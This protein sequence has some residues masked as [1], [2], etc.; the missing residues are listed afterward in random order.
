MTNLRAY[1]HARADDAPQESEITNATVSPSDPGMIEWEGVVSQ[2]TPA[3]QFILFSAQF[4][5][6]EHSASASTTYSYVQDLTVSVFG[7]DTSGD[8][9]S[10]TGVGSYISVCTFQTTAVVA[11]HAMQSSVSSA[12]A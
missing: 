8:Y 5:N 7:Y 10:D 1:V 4:Q 6:P 12:G 3:N 11:E 9:R 2:V